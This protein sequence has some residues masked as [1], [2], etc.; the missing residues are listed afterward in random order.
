MK[1]NTIIKSTDL[2]SSKDKVIFNS[3]GNFV[4][5]YG[6]NFIDEDEE[7]KLQAEVEL[8]DNI[9][10]LLIDINFSYKRHCGRC[11]KVSSFKDSNT[12]MTRLN[13]KEDNDYEINFE[14]DYYDLSP[15]ISESI[16]EKMDINFICDIKC[17][18]LCSSC[19]ANLNKLTCN[20][21]EKNIKESPFSSLSQLD[22]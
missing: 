20:C 4:I 17:R 10:S 8:V 7:I 5:N 18:G 6:N 21:S 13:I 9:I 12:F 3:L 11:L 19:G 22:L 2:I 1:L 16:I 14:D 15:F